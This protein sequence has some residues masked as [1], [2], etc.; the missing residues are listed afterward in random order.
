MAKTTDYRACGAA[1][2]AILAANN[3]KHLQINGKTVIINYQYG[4]GTISSREE[5]QVALT[6]ADPP[7][8]SMGEADPACAEAIQRYFPDLP[9][10]LA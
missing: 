6:V 3:G 8:A 10:L 2:A 5:Y 7:A 9:A 4:Y 1:D